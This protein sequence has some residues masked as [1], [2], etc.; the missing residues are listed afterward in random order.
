MGEKQ[1]LRLGG[2]AG[3]IYVVAN[4]V[5]QSIESN[6]PNLNAST[7]KIT[8]YFAVHRH[9]IVIGEIIGVA[10]FA[11]ALWWLGTIRHAF[12]RSGEGND[13]L[14]W[15]A[16]AAGVAAATLAVVGHLGTVL[17]AML[18]GQSQG[19]TNASVV[20]V[21][22]DMSSASPSLVM[23]AAFVPAVGIAAVRRGMVGAWLG[24]LAVIDGGV[25]AAGGASSL[26]I[27]GA[28]AWTIIF[29]VGL[30]GF[31]LV[32]L[33]LSIQMLRGRGIASTA[34]TAAS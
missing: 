3:I 12:G 34:R 6:V 1:W 8:T 11:F 33:I 22:F 14:G 16:F 9:T 4:V 15:I 7:A 30:I 28:S 31:A 13:P 27:G 24:W 17:L 32:V 26:A 2:L 25:A 20:R 18:A 10:A 5:G 29:L 19:L 21:L 23:F